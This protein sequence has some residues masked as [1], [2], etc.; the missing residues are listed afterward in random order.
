M[1][2]RESE[3]LA[4][5]MGK[6]IAEAYPSLN[7][8]PHRLK[9][10]RIVDSVEVLTL[11]ERDLLAILKQ[12]PVLGVQ[13]LPSDDEDQYRLTW[14]L[15]TDVMLRMSLIHL[16]KLLVPKVGLVPYSLFAV[17]RQ[18]LVISWNAENMR[19]L[20]GL[21]IELRLVDS[22]EIDRRVFSHVLF[23]Y[24]MPVGSIQ[25][26]YLLSELI[27]WTHLQ[28][29][30]KKDHYR[31]H[32]R[33]FPGNEKWSRNRLPKNVLG[34]DFPRNGVQLAYLV[35]L[36]NTPFVSLTLLSMLNLGAESH[37]TLGQALAYNWRLIQ[38]SLNY[39][40]KCY[41]QGNCLNLSYFPDAPKKRKMDEDIA[42]TQETPACPRPR[43]C[44]PA[45]RSVG[46]L[47]ETLPVLSPLRR[48]TPVDRTMPAIVE[49]VDLGSQETPW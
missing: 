39:C 8:S 14:L 28:T 25:D 42:A 48:L 17:L 49:E 16:D 40:D 43:V 46:T 13:I 22:M 34:W 10:V 27:L 12:C 6:Y 11:L 2:S 26:Y 19:G 31:L 4:R 47:T 38:F 36:G 44:C 18:S 24:Q 33:N 41:G 15:I 30:L 32:R 45:G 29:I 3:N 1:L 7:L 9:Q 5:R 37:K 35:N 20:L 21:P 23:P